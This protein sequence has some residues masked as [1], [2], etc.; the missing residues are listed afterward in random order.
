[1]NPQNSQPAVQAVKAAARGFTLLEMLLYLGFMSIVLV[2]ATVLLAEFSVT[3]RVRTAAWQEVERNAHFALNRVA[4]EVREAS[5]L[6]PGDSVFDTNPGRL[7]LGLSDMTRNPTVFYVDDG[8]LYV[9]QGSDTAL[10]LTSSKI[11]VKEFTIQDV[12]SSAIH[13]NYRLH[14]KIGYRSDMPEAAS[15]EMTV[16]TTAQIKTGDGYS[17]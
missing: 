11:D 15:A 1:M 13:R 2:A 8:T 17:D 3:A 14:L 10:A 7:S 9:Q 4:V 16:E 5:S 12:S 6:N